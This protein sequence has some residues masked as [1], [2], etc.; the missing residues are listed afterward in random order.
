M[1]LKD[2]RVGEHARHG[3][4]VAVAAVHGQVKSESVAVLYV[5]VASFTAAESVDA[6]VEGSV[7]LDQNF[8]LGVATLHSN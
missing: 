6:T 8:D 1:V 7:G 3:L 4:S 5:N 2:D